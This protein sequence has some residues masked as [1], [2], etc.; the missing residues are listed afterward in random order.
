MDLIAIMEQEGF[1]PVRVKGSSKEEY[2]SSCPSCGGKDRF[3][4]WPERNKF[5]CRGC[6]IKGD[7]IDFFIKIKGL[8]FKEAQKKARDE[9]DDKK[10]ESKQDNG[11]PLWKENKRPLNHE[12]WINKACN[13]IE[14][15]HK[16]LFESIEG[17]HVLKQLENMKG[18]KPETARR[19]CLGWNPRDVFRER[20]EWGL[21]D[22]I[23]DNGKKKKL[24]IASG[25]V[26]PTTNDLILENIRF[27]L[28]N[29]RDTNKYVLLSG[30]S[31]GY[32]VAGQKE[33]EVCFVVESDLDAILLY[34]EAGDIACFVATGSTSNKPGRQEY[35]F[36]KSKRLFLS[37]D[38]DEAG[39]KAMNG[40]WKEH[41]PEAEIWPI[42]EGK[43]PSEAF[44]NGLDLRGWIQAALIDS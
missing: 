39:R 18:I 32:M 35:E 22:E 42:I 3:L 4:I 7:D 38:S 34:Q 26:I 40:Y 43:D 24:W 14:Y 13:F 1:N 17:N 2:S 6:E 5:W 12:I 9:S 19:F 44:K 41:F 10:S 15:A 33:K 21:K 23:K 37:L 30:S 8:S 20:A 36:L 11:S 31:G 27:R 16:E 28:R 29:P 25:L